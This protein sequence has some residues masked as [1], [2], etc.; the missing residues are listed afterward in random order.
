MAK[1]KIT[2]VKGLS[3]IVPNQKATIQALGF[4]KSYQ[5]IE[6]EVNPAVNGMIKKVQH[7]LKVENI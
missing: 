1:V 5:Q 6:K 4:K 7:L 2:L 3:K